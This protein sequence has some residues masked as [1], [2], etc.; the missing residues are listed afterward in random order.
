MIF[1]VIFNFF[2]L[3]VLVGYSFAFNRFINPNKTEIHN[4]EVL[5]GLFILIF[6]SLFLNFFFPLKSFFYLVTIIGFLFFVEG[7]IKKKIKIK[8]YIHFLILFLLI[9]V[10]YGHGDNVDSPMYHLQ[11]I[12]WLQNEK[13]VFGLSNLEIR[14]GSNSL[15]FGL[16][17]LLKFKINNFNSIY[18]FNLIPFSILFY[19]VFNKENKLSY[20]FITLT[21]SFI[22]LFFNRFC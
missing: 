11:I 20:I 4:L 2:L 7:W 9:F 5:Y 13:I 8:L 19:Q 12:K 21:I 1:T 3:S 17:S 16:F 14:F 22:L 18:T 6:I 10:T 15:W